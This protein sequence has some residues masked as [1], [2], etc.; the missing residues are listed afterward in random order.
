MSRT[1]KPA[2]S[3]TPS[4]IAAEIVTLALEQAVVYRSDSVGVLF[5]GPLNEELRK[6][7]IAELPAD[8]RRRRRAFDIDKAIK[9]LQEALGTDELRALLLDVSN[10]DND[11]AALDEE[12]AYLIGLEMGRAVPGVGGGR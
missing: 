5:D 9:R 10:W 12:A 7:I 11:E 2:T 4:Q 6:A 1:K 3:R 8:A